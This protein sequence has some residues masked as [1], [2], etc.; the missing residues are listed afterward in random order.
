MPY[1]FTMCLF[2]YLLVIVKSHIDA[3]I[4]RKCVINCIHD[5]VMH[6]FR[7]FQLF[8][9]GVTLFGPATALEAGM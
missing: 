4:I 5:L 3:H 6:I 8:L 1:K 2:S 7:P 9:T